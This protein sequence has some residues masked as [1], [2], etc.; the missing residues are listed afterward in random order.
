MIDL[1]VLTEYGPVR[2]FRADGCSEFL[3]IPFAKPPV[4]ELMF[5]HP[6]KPEPWTDVL[7]ASRGS[8]NPVQGPSSFGPKC[9][10]LDCLYLN[11]FVPEGL[12][13]PLPVMVWI[14]GG[15]YSHG[16]IGLVE[17]GRDELTYDMALFARE[18]GTIVVTFNYRLNLY[19][20]LPLTEFGD[21][22]DA[23]N[24]LYDQIMALRFVKD[25]IASFGGDPDNVTVF[26][27]S[28]GG[29]CILALMTMPE[30]KGLFVRSIVQSAC[31][32]HFFTARE[33]RANTRRY[34]KIAGIDPQHP[35][36]LFSLSK[37]AVSEINAKFE[38]AML[39][40]WDL[41]CAFSPIIDG[42]TLREE[43]KLAVCQSE[44]PM[45]IGNTSDEACTFLHGVPLFLYPI[46]ARLMRFPV[47][48]GSEKVS[49]R[50]INGMT[51]HIYKRPMREILK[52]Y[53]GPAWKY[54]YQYVSAA[55][56]AAGLGCY[57]ASELAVMFSW[58]TVRELNDPE[59]LRVGRL[60]RQY[61]GT[62]AHNGD[63]GWENWGKAG[64][65]KEIN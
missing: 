49:K 29:A 45:M 48:K 60:L 41:R 46:V 10:N 21:R 30:A 4:G 51:D 56:R 9:Q 2:G 33:S 16:G 18:T 65:T 42:V 15:S 6:V 14:Y 8:A 64:V 43:P 38:K 47:P 52:D 12:E 3:G 27:Q 61:W 22:F 28:A 44:L 32:E 54:E 36:A 19:G 62:F 13:G 20:F 5:K 31:I 7:E 40:S 35:E 57:H 59:T 25:N 58:S 17:D 1:T 53:R 63:P 55:E 37:D 50:V 11:V 26:G 39:L 23:N 34:L 24:G